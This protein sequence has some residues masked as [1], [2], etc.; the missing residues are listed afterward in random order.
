MK[1]IESFLSISKKSFFQILKNPTRR[2]KNLAYCHCLAPTQN[3]YYPCYTT[4][5]LQRHAHLFKNTWVP[6][7]TNFVITRAPKIFT[8]LRRLTLNLQRD[9][10]LSL[11]VVLD[12]SN[13]LSLRCTLVVGRPCCF[14]NTYKIQENYGQTASTMFSICCIVRFA[15]TNSSF[16]LTLN[17]FF[18]SELC[19]SLLSTPHYPQYS[20][21]P[22]MFPRVVVA[23]WCYVKNV[24]CTH[25]KFCYCKTVWATVAPLPDKGGNIFFCTALIKLLMQ[26]NDSTPNH[27]TVLS[28]RASEFRPPCA[29]TKSV[30][31]SILYR[32]LTHSSAL[33]SI[34]PGAF[35]SMSC[36]KIIFFLFTAL[37]SHL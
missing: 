21:W 37:Y 7:I 8:R 11:K 23:P 14:P 28:R 29:D 10:H 20:V 3:R 30:P 31:S 17:L 26:H 35:I 2:R 16:T 22:T 33:R 18:C 25:Y 34:S 6:Q 32:K 36:K 27:P 13:S 24:Y 9:V 15:C 4:N 1:S 19:C 5:V 12:W